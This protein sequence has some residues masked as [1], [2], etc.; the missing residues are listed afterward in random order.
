MGGDPLILF[1]HGAGVGSASD[2]MQG[3]RARL[4]R[5]GHVVTF[6]YP[7]MAA[8]NKRPDPHDALL[9][10]HREALGEARAGHDGPVV[11]AGKSMGSRIGCHL[12]LEEEVQAL[13]CFGYP[14]V[15]PG[16]TRKVRS[17]VLE[18]LTTP[19]LLL[20]GTRDRLCPL[21]ELEEV[22][23]RMTAHNELHVVEEGDHSLV[24]TKRYL[25]AHD[26]TQD[27]VDDQTLAA[28]QRF[29]N[30]TT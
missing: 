18:K 6:D 16:K 30:D 25:R 3:W 11:L 4:E 20:Q 17:E 14:L 13:V 9:A 21:D 12:S 23:A 26:T 19:I 1:A 28:V 10:A 2:W 5:L 24:V 7:Y 15:S 27:A 8:G 29:L 22:R